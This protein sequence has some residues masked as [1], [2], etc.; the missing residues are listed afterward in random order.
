MNTLNLKKKAT[1]EIRIE[2]AIPPENPEIKGHLMC[3]AI[4]RGTK[5]MAE[6]QERIDNGELVTQE[7]LLVRGPL[8]TNIRG[9]GND[10][11]ECDTYDKALK[12]VTEGIYSSYLVPALVQ[13]YFK[14]YNKD[15]VAKNLPRS[16]GR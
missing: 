5:Q 9:L 7:D 8:Y 1:V 15:P 13:G 11:G 2:I 12:E 4:I 3:D 16:R 10:D 14:H 6:L